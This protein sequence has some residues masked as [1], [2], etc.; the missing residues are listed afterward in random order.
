MDR[1]EAQV[2]DD[3]LLVSCIREEETGEV[4]LKADECLA[5]LALEVL[6]LKL[7]FKNV[8]E[9]DNLQGFQALRKLCLDNNVI[10]KIE[11]VGHLVTLEWLDLSFN[12]IEKIEGLETLTKLT[13][14]SLFQ[15]RIRDIEN[16]E[17]C[18]ELECLSLGNNKVSALESVV[19]LRPFKKLRL[20]NLEG[21]PVA[22]ES[23]Y[24]M[25]ILSYLNTL[26]YLD[27]SVVLK[28]ETVAARE[29]YQDE[30][31]DVEEKEALE[32][33]KIA[34]EENAKKYTAKLTEANLHF[35]ESLFEDLFAD[36]TEMQTKLRYLPGVDDV[37]NSFQS[38]VDIASDTFVQAGL[39]KFEEKEAAVK[40]FETALKELREKYTSDS[41]EN[42]EAFAKFKKHTLRKLASSEE[43][44]DPS[45]FNA[46]EAAE[47]QPIFDKLDEL[48]ETLMDFEMY[49]QERFEKLMNDIQQKLTDM[50]DSALELQQSYFRTLEDHESAYTKEILQLVQDLVDRNSRDELEGLNINDDAMAFLDDRDACLNAVTA[51]HDIHVSKLF[52]IEDDAKNNEERQTKAT[53]KQYKD[54]EHQ[55][56][57]QRIF[58]IITYKEKI[59][60]HLRD[61]TLP[62][63]D[64][65]NEQLLLD[66]D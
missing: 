41:I 32:F 10:K 30:L 66:Q 12:C 5:S 61:L 13:D 39:G 6:T 3:E 46:F 59:Q 9:V 51:S 7:S 21:N 29:Q 52:K 36:D 1:L 38:E 55:R 20:L 25:Y 11:N 45:L 27:Y 63:Q 58:E 35:V 65:N 31:L 57:R 62:N 4:C 16:L 18:L 26:T 8:L 34:R 37:Y 49:Q 28:A 44:G 54:T 64:E 14:L 60:G 53:I 24:R 15:N 56:N 19:K 17:K 42:V 47:I 33:E 43:G 50:K 48:Y 40:F 22:K 23:E 2:I